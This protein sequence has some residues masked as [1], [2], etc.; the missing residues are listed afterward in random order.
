M[1]R[2][3]QAADVFAKID[4]K[5]GDRTQCWPWL[6]SLTDKGVPSYQYNGRK[7]AAYAV[8][9]ECVFGP[10]LSGEVPR[11]TCDNGS[12]RNDTGVCCCNP[13]HIERGTVADNNKDIAI[14]ARHGMSAYV[15]RAMRKLV[16]DEKRSVKE[17][18]ALYGVSDQT[19]RD[20][21]SGK[22]HVP[23]DEA[24]PSAALK[25]PARVSE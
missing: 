5:L 19:V 3:N 8:A 10:L 20:I 11:H 2:K 23:S 16:I 18:A 12:G 22:T 15:R 7:R 21:V 1:A 13:W 25:A 9:F 14:R 4:M 17:V 6:G 24:A